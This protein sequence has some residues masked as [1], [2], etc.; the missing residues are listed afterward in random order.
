[1]TYLV[2]ALLGV[3]I[4]GR[5]EASGIGPVAVEPIHERYVLVTDKLENGLLL[6]DIYLHKTVGRAGAY[7]TYLTNTMKMVHTLGRV[8]LELPRVPRVLSFG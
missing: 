4:V 1:M 2:H 6:A 5:A 3:S 8:S 7:S